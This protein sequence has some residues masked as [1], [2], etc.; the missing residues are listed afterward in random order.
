MRA[1]SA[2][3]GSVLCAGPVA[4]C[5]GAAPSFVRDGTLTVCLD[6]SFPP[7]E[8]YRNPGDAA[9]VG[10]DVDFAAALAQEWQAQLRLMPAEFTGL[11]PAL[12]A[13]RCDAVI[14]GV[15]LKPE[16]TAALAAIPYLSTYVVIIG[17]ADSK[18][19]VSSELDLAGKTI[20]TESGTGYAKLLEGINA[21]VRAAKR[22]PMLIQTYPKD[23]DAI[24]QL[25][26]G[27][28]AGVASQDIEVG[29][30]NAQGQNFKI[31]YR[32]PV[33]DKFAVYIRPDPEDAA[34]VT[35]AV[36]RLRATGKLKAIA[37]RWQL[38]AETLDIE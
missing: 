1:L 23:S 15:L 22:A 18:L 2:L 38:P 32:F 4:V 5:L 9:P 19:R 7:M 26:I 17:R 33:A 25:Q 14:S 27:R 16:R 30:R 8:F 21:K 24:Q 37:E 34:G 35:A 13:R 6:P 28:A 20:A 12:Q 11:L 29:E 3:I 31:L 10:V 36:T